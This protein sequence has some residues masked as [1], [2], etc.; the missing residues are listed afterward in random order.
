M[1]KITNL[2]RVRSIAIVAHPDDETI[3]MGGTIMKIRS[4]DWT[5]FS[6]CRRSDPDRAPKFFRVCHFYKAQ[7]IMTDLDDEGRLSF[8][9]SVKAAKKLIKKE[10]GKQK[11]DCVFT[12]GPNGEYGHPLHKA[13][14]RAVKELI[15]EKVLAPAVVFYFS[16]R[17]TSRKAFSTLKA[18][19]DSDLLLKLSSPELKRKKEIMTKIYGFAPAGIDVSYCTDPEAYK[20]YQ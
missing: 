3:W 15:A 19:K 10:I 6:L 8:D 18:G 5:I 2:N 11:F 1:K 20:I 14:H 16:Y 17:K 13:V 4:H 9:Q 12:H 7:A